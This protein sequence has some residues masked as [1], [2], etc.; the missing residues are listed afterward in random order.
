MYAPVSKQ[1]KNFYAHSFFAVH[2]RK[3]FVQEHWFA[4]L[5][6]I[7]YVHGGDRWMLVV[8]MTQIDAFTLQASFL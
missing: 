1:L 7:R 4:H 3:T 6:Y 5:D 2:L 8:H